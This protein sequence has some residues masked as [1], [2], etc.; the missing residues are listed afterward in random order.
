MKPGNKQET[1]L[2]GS[3]SGKYTQVGHL[4]ARYQAESALGTDDNIYT[5]AEFTTEC[6]VSY[7]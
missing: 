1:L 2:A 3:T 5:E 4:L 7:L 6:G